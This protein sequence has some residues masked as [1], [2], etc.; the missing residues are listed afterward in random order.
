MFGIQAALN[1]SNPEIIY[2]VFKRNSKI[3]KWQTENVKSEDRQDRGHMKDKYR[4]R[5]ITL[6]TKGGVTRNLQKPG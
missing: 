2:N 4:T 5:N 1:P 3:P 6:K